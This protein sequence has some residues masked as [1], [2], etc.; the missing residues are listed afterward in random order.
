[1]ATNVEASSPN[2]GDSEMKVLTIALMVAFALCLVFLPSDRD[3][4]AEARQEAVRKEM[5]ATA[6]SD[7]FPVT[8]DASR[9]GC[10]MSGAGRD[11]C[12]ASEVALRDVAAVRWAEAPPPDRF[13]CL[14]GMGEAYGMAGYLYACLGAAR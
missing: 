2:R 11:A 1:M 6:R 8:A 5:R 3:A 7:A 14:E 10:G 9:R 13:R 4:A 12:L